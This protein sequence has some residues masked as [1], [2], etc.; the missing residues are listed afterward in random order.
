MTKSYLKVTPLVL[1]YLRS[2]MSITLY[3][4]LYLIVQE[5]R[6]H[7]EMSECYFNLMKLDIQL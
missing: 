5:P 2:V 1:V 7:L 4:W 3:E 6:N